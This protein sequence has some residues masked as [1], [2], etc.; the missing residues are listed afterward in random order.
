MTVA[1]QIALNALLEQA[2]KIKMTPEQH[3]AQRRSWVRGQI[4]LAHPELSAAEVR[5]AVDQALDGG[6]R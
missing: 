1:N 6:K 3:E 5:K 2:A 4:G